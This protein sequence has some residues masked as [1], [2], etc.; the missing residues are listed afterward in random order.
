[1][2]DPEFPVTSSFVKKILGDDSIPVLKPTDLLPERGIVIGEAVSADDI[3]AWA[4]IIDS[5]WML[6]G[7][8]DFYTALLDKNYQPQ[9]Q[10]KPALQS[11]HL[12]VC[13]TAF[14]ER[15]ELIKQLSEE[16][17]N[18]VSYLPGTVDETW[19]KK[20]GNILKE[21]NKV[22]IAIDES[23]QPALSL[24]KIMANAVKEI[25]SRGNIK[26]IFIEGGSTAAAIL[27]VS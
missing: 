21:Q 10:Q 25:I 12:Y 2:N 8:G 13:G 14:N 5:T 1:V 17:K 27:V 4:G 18:C 11:P 16:S 3:K 9:H 7:A 23:T 24:R 20:T 26:E 22:I 15:K 6:V 19:L